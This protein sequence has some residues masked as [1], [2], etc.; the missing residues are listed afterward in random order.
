[1]TAAHARLQ[2]AVAATGRLRGQVIGSL[3]ESLDLLQRSFSAGKV[4][5][6][7]LLVFRREFVESEREYV[8]V[9]ADAWRARIELDLAAG[10]LSVPV[11]DSESRLR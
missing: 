4:G 10:R 1:V 9:L 7:E 5:A 2:A 8:A 3:E 11:V 6:M